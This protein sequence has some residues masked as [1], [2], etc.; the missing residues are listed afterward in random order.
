MH[1]NH[2]DII[3]ALNCSVLLRFREGLA[4]RKE[5]RGEKERKRIGIHIMAVW[6]ILCGTLKKAALWQLWP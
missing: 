2:N 1:N 4:R 3:F 6:V 5:A